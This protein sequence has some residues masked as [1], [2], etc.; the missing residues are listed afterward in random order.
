MA[1]NEDRPEVEAPDAGDFDLHAWIGGHHTYPEYSVKIHLDKAAVVESNKLLSEIEKLE[2]EFSELRELAEKATGGGGSL[3]EEADNTKRYRLVGKEL[4]EKKA[5]RVSI[6]DKAK[7]SAL[8][9]VLC[10][11]S[12]GSEDEDKSNPFDY[13]RK[14]LAEEFP[15]HV[16]V[17]NSMDQ[18]QTR[19][20]FTE[21]PE[22]SHRQNV[23]LFHV[24]IASITNPQGQ[25]IERGPKLGEENISV[26]IKRLENSDINRLQLNV[27]L[28]MSG[29][30]LREEQIDAGF[31]G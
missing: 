24:M 14:T 25:T 20:L 1:E 7:N 3:G 2:T 6:L 5:A 18:D 29:A 4:K 11:P 19:E 21:H 28:A 10:K 13:V 22:I 16:K 9:V 31:P 8:T 26:L 30:E 12:V 23:L 15:D 27:N 17:L